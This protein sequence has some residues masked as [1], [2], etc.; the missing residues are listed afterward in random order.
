VLHVTIEKSQV[1]DEERVPFVTELSAYHRQNV[2]NWG[3][4]MGSDLRLPHHDITLNRGT[5][6]PRRRPRVVRVTIRHEH[7]DQVR[8]EHLNLDAQFLHSPPPLKQWVGASPMGP[9]APHASS[10]SCRWSWTCPSSAHLTPEAATKRPPRGILAVLVHLN[11]FA[12][13]IQYC[14]ILSYG[15]GHIQLQNAT[16]LA[17][18]GNSN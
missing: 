17:Y 2:P 4:W 15:S 3:R 11:L 16:R 9:P 14:T 1:P 10:S 5:C 18:F 8:V 6:I 13:P 12:S 7:Y